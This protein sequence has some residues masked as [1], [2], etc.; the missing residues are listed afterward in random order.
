V[1]WVLGGQ[2][3]GGRIAGEQVVVNPSSLLQHRDYPV[4]TNYRDLLGGLFGRLWGLSESRL[5]AVFPQAH[6]RDLQLV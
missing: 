4:L 2:V 3:R 1:H 5:Q 6:A